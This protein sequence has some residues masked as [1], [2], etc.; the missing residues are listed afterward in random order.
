MQGVNCGGIIM[1]NRIAMS[2]RRYTIYES[3]F[4]A[5]TNTAK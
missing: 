3:I 2:M 1:H 4:K 5:E